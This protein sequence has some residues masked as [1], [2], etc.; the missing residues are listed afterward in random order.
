MTKQCSLYLYRLKVDHISDY[1][2][3]W[4]SSSVKGKI[5]NKLM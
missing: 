4:I 5:L 1:V 2:V 3:G